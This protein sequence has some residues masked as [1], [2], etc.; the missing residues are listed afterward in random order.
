MVLQL[1]AIPLYHSVGGRVSF[2]VAA[3][4]YYIKRLK[5]YVCVRDRVCVRV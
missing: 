4:A 2:C 3:P 1:A 5:Y